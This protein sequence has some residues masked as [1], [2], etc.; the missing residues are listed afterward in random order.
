MGKPEQ[1]VSLVPKRNFKTSSTSLTST[2]IQVRA[3]TI[4]GSLASIEQ[5]NDM[6]AWYCKAFKTLGEA[7]YSAVVKQAQSGRSPRALFG[8]LLKKEMQ[9]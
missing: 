9:R 2:E 7:R 1:L 4:A 6:T 8:Y 5:P 3:L